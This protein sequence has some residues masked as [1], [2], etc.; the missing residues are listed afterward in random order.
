MIIA[1]RDAF[2]L[3]YQQGEVNSTLVFDTAQP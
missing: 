3:P 2:E 1:D